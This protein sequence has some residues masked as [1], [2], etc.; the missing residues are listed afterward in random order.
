MSDKKIDINKFEN[1]QKKNNLYL[2][3]PNK[4][5]EFYF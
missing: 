5:E 2:K 4:K 3:F 1:L